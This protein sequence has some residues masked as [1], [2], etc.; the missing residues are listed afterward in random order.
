MIAYL[1]LSKDWC[2]ICTVCR[3]NTELITHGTRNSV[4]TPDL[5]QLLPIYDK[6]EHVKRFNYQFYVWKQTLLA[7]P[8]IPSPS[9]HGWLLRDDLLNIQSMENIPAPESVLEIMVCQCRKSACGNMCQCPILRLEYNL[10]KCSGS[11]SNKT[12]TNDI[13]SKIDETDDNSI[14]SETSDTNSEEEH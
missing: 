8:D 3:R 7:N 14:K 4:K 11:C 2:V 10:C 5:Q 1:T 12:E 13:K 9:G 6:L